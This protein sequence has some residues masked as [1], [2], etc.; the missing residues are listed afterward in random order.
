MKEDRAFG[1]DLDFINMPVEQHSHMEV[2][3]L[4]CLKGCL[5]VTI[6]G[7]LFEFSENDIAVINSGRKHS[8][9][10]STDDLGCRISIDYELLAREAGQGMVVFN[11]NTKLYPGQS[12]ENL[13]HILVE[14]VEEYAIA[15]HMDF[16]KKELFYRMLVCLMNRYVHE[17]RSKSEAICEDEVM[18]RTLNYI[19]KNIARPLSLKFAASLNFMSES[20]FSKYFKRKIG[21]NF[22][23]YVR[24]LRLERA[25]Q[26]LVYTDK[27]MSEIA[28]DCGYTNSSVFT[29]AFRAMA[30]CAPTQFRRKARAGSENGGDLQNGGASQNSKAS[31]N[32]KAAAYLISK[33]PLSG[34]EGVGALGSAAA[35]TLP[36]P[37]M[38][39]QPLKNAAAA[40]VKAHRE[41]ASRKWPC[42]KIWVDASGG[43]SWEPVWNQCINAGTAAELLSAKLQQQ[44]VMLRE[45]L[46]FKYVRISNIFSNEMRLR[47]GQDYEELNFEAV[48]TVLD[49]IV[50]NGMHPIIEAG[51]KPRRAMRS[52]GQILFF[53]D[54]GAVFH[55]SK[56]MEDMYKRFIRHVALRYG[57]DEAQQWIFENWYDGRSERALESYNYLDTFDRIWEIV[58]GRLPKA[59]VGG[60]GLELGG[61]LPSFLKEWA[62][63]KHLPD[64]ISLC[65]FPYRR[66]VSGFSSGAAQR[67]GDSHFML[68]TLK[69]VKTYLDGCGLGK[70]D[71][72][73]TEWNLSISDRNYF[74][75]CC[76]KGALML[77]AMKEL[78]GLVKMGAY[79]YGSDINTS[80]YDTKELLFGG[81]GLITKDSLKKPAFFAMYFMKRLGRQTLDSGD[82]CIAAT[83]GDGSYELLLFNYK[84]LN[85]TYYLKDEA[86]VCVSDTKRIFEN[87][88]G[89]EFEILIKNVVPGEYFIKTEKISPLHGNLL[90]EWTELGNTEALGMRDFDYLR[91]ICVPKIH[92]R[93]AFARK[94][95]LEF[96]QLLEP[97]EMCFVHIFPSSV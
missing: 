24:E 38:L 82:G 35:Q 12:Y 77:Q 42:R 56:E 44:I 62:A 70:I 69:E 14:I 73:L 34:H 90:L 2:E 92:I 84:Y 74:N 53:E 49:F 8:I 96:T 93:K 81:A 75:D 10:M 54:K 26:E 55:S 85:Y 61:P 20:A 39:A 25:K 36:G 94:N 9:F 6:E 57:V 67:S 52:S 19:S 16:R 7:Q 40:F 27:T 48:D 41:N 63:H 47:S 72:Y 80:Y 29:K 46:G 30:G 68:N 23:Q 3:L 87:E 18:Q 50:G 59:K 97:H 71:L 65:A 45:N 58:K 5:K 79:W 78:T 28:L 64:F 22:V 31:Q 91:Q 83:N 17:F 4:Y 37:G 88:D 15:E 76:G 43:Q 51:D 95:I 11:C 13:C 33:Q 60:C 32:G 86:C 66:N 89:L 21:M 1:I